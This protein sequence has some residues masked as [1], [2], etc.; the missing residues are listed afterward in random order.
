MSISTNPPPVH[1]F[2]DRSRTEILGAATG[3]LVRARV[4]HYAGIGPAESRERLEELFELL[5]SAAATRQL[6]ESLAYARR[7]AQER[8]S[9]GYDLSEVQTAINLLEE[10][11]WKAAFSHLGPDRYLE[12]L[13]LVS[14]ILGT[15]KDALAREYV[16]L[17]TSARAPAPHVQALFAGT[18]G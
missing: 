5:R 7:L 4:P 8:F 12:T 16:A 18:D 13:G 1:V 9:A 2:L 11:T 17:A 6:T 15:I 10:A 14:T 3:A